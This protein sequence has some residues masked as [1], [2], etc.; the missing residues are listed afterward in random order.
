MMEDME[1]F[2]KKGRRPKV[3]NTHSIK[4]IIEQKI[5]LKKIINQNMSFIL[6]FFLLHK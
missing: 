2:Q 1:I 3:H 5:A 4:D 6:L